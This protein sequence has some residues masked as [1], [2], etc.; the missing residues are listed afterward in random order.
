MDKLK[1][2]MDIFERMRSGEAVPMND[3]EYV[4]IREAVNRTFQLQFNAGL[5]LKV[6]VDKKAFTVRSPDAVSFSMVNGAWMNLKFTPGRFSK[7]AGAEGPQAAALSSNH[8]YVYGTQGNPDEAGL[9]ARQEQAT[10]AADWAF[11]RPFGGRV[12]IFPRSMADNRVRQSDIETSNLVLFGTAATN[13]WINKYADRLPMQ[14]NEN[15]DGYGLVYI[16]PMN[17]RYL[18]INSGLSWW[19]PPA[20]TEGQAGGIDRLTGKG[21]SLNAFPDFILFKGTPDNVISSGYFDNNWQ[22]PE[23]EKAKLKASG[24]VQIK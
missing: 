21:S 24:V 13:S 16:F 5:P 3:P 9:R 18:L 19:T 10:Y 23:T 8:I 4:K 14:L 17:G 2:D 20:S 22:I 6:S 11:D 7:Q 1:A 15:A 12:M